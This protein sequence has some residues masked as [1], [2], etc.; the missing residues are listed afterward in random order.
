M[1]KNVQLN[2][3]KP[4]HED[5]AAMRPE[6]KGRFC[7]SCCKTVVDFSLMSDREVLGY[8]GG[9]SD[10]V[11]GRFTE[12][13]LQRDLIHPPHRKRKGWMVWN[14]LMTTLLLAS[15]T[16]GQAKAPRLVSHQL[17]PGKGVK[18]PI[19]MGASVS[20]VAGEVAASEPQQDTLPLVPHYT[21]LPPAVVMGYRTTGK[22]DIVGGATAGVMIVKD[23]AT[24]SI[25]RLIK[26]SLAF[27]GI[28]KKEFTL[29]PNPA[30]RG[31]TIR[32]SLDMEKTGKGTIGLYNEA[33]SLIQA[34]AVEMT[35]APLMEL[36][37]L[38]SSIPG[39]LY[40][41]RLSLAESKKQ[42]TRKL[43]VL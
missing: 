17:D 36:F 2:I 28:V 18:Q 34:K 16:R 26:D 12:D 22:V 20:M 30:E 7:S 25:P 24:P 3:P 42:Y 6:E 40:F 43:I 19:L 15:K 11:C 39:G 8:L 37:N 23:T 9:V 10:K 35:G 41:V 32:F 31:T 38:P 13:Q 21:E 33:G 1:K 5:W 29:Y 4:C 27:L 14:I